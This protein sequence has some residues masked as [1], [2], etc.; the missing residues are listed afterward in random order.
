MRK[1]K[2]GFKTPNNEYKM[3]PMCG[4]QLEIDKSKKYYTMG[5]S[6]EESHYAEIE[7]TYEEAKIVNRILKELQKDARGYCGSCW[8]DFE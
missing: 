2:C 6:A 7:M 3:C 8:I 5:L 4:Q 1:C